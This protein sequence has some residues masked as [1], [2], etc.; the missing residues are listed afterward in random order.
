[1]L[2]VKDNVLIC[3]VCTHTAHKGHDCKDLSEAYEEDKKLIGESLMVAKQELKQ[4]QDAIQSVT[5]VK[6]QLSVDEKTRT[7]EIEKYFT[8]VSI[9]VHSS[10]V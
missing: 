1:M 3:L 5:K 4:T 7:T 10:V 2:C 8:Q 9:F 6:H